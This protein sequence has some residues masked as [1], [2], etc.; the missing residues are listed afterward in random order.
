MTTRFAIK[1]VPAEW[2]HDLP[3]PFDRATHDAIDLQQG[4]RILIYQ[5][6]KGIVGEGEVDGF[7]VQPDEWMPSSKDDLPV[8]LADA[9]YLLPLRML[10]SR[11]DP[12]PPSSVQ[13]VLDDPAFPNAVLWR[14][15]SR[16]EYERLNSFPP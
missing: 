13:Q 1:V 12:I 10:Y 16:N 11:R 8:L 2:Q 4:T 7:F 3:L 15:L 5:R 9:E 14:P 6:G